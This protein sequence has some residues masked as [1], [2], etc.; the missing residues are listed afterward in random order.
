MTAVALEPK[1]LSRARIPGIEESQTQWLRR[2]DRL[3]ET[4]F[5]SN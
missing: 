3:T 5:P 2:S 1:I 4:C